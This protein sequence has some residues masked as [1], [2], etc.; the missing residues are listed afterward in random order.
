MP[1]S[2]LRLALN[3]PPNI[4]SV[5]IFGVCQWFDLGCWGAVFGL[6]GRQHRCGNNLLGAQF[7]N[8]YGRNTAWQNSFLREACQQAVKAPKTLR[9]MAWAASFLF[10]TRKCLA[11]RSLFER[12]FG[13]SRCH[14]GQ[15]QQI[16]ANPLKWSQKVYQRTL[17]PKDADCANGTTCPAP[18]WT[19]LTQQ[20]PG[21]PT[22]D[23]AFNSAVTAGISGANGFYDLGGVVTSQGTNKWTLTPAP[24]YALDQ[25]HPNLARYQLVRAANL[26]PA[27]TYP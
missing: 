26:I 15:I 25:Q 24:P 10:R 18:T 5:K 6:R 17:A 11:S 4:H 8:Q 27:L 13:R 16:F 2:R 12:S 14:C 22:E 9:Q 1:Q 23:T 19:T 21:N 20:T 7:K 3:T